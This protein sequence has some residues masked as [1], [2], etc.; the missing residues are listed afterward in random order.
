MRMSERLAAVPEKTYVAVFF[1]IFL[2]AVFYAYF[3]REDTALLEGRIAMKQRDLARILQLRDTYEAKKHELDRRALKRP[4]N[5]P[6]SLA[7][8]ESMVGKSFVG[9]N[10]TGLTPTAS[11]GEKGSKQMA[12]E[13]KV[14]NAA[15]GEVVAF[16]RSAEDAGLRVE[17]LRLSL[18]ASN[19]TALDMQA[20]IVE[21]R[22]HG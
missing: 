20:T 21:R 1:G 18:P 2:L 5:Q 15:L 7:L 3:T 19:P 17:K 11:K 8:I 16:V 14:A 6:M 12:I 22:S 10:L 9:G 13:L 4:D